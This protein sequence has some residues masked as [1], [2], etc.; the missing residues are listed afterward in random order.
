MKL[1]G[2]L[3]ISL[4][5]LTACSSSSDPFPEDYSN[6]AP[7][8]VPQNHVEEEMK[9][10]VYPLAPGYSLMVRKTRKGNW[11]GIVTP[12]I[13]QVKISPPQGKVRKI[14][15]DLGGERKENIVACNHLSQSVQGES[16]YSAYAQQ[17]MN[18]YYVHFDD[19]SQ[20]FPELQ[21]D[22]DAK[23]IFAA[24]NIEKQF[25]SLR[26]RALRKED[27]QGTFVLQ[28]GKNSLTDI[29]GDQSNRLSNLEKFTG[30]I[31][32][33]C[34]LILGNASFEIPMDRS[35]DGIHKIQVR[36]KDI[37]RAW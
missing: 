32:G 23:Q 10:G 25:T 26:I 17:I 5:G 13:L 14:K 36:F 4:L 28:M 33:Y 37:G 6:P 12:H 19:D 34:D 22:Y 7:T 8:P 35:A 11:E 18:E 30:S 2:I 15:N 21:D 31:F 9:S 24:H 16:G 1:L 29:Y 20:I 27:I 3:G